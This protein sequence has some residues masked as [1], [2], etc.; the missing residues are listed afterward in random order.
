MPSAVVSRMA[1][2][3]SAL[4]WP[5]GEGCRRSRGLARSRR[6][7]RRFPSR[8][9]RRSAP[10]RIVV[11]AD[12]VE[13][14]VDRRGRR[15]FARGVGL[16]KSSPACRCRRCCWRSRRRARHRA[17]RGRRPPP[18]HEGSHS[19]SARETRGWHRA[20]G[21]AGRSARRRAADRAA[22]GRAG[23]AARRRLGLRPASRLFADVRR[24][25]ARPAARSRPLAVRG[26]RRRCA[27]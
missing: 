11:P 23:F 25:A 9:P 7:H 24:F 3:S 14:R 22:S 18:A 1:P 6:R 21:R 12:G 26:C 4:A 17:R 8:C 5:T 20:A 19:P 16:R 2:S 27:R 15:V 10:A 13:P